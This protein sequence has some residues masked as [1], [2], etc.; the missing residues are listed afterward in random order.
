MDYTVNN[1]SNKFKIKQHS[2]LFHAIADTVRVCQETYADDLKEGTD[3][4]LRN[5]INSMRNRLDSF[6]KNI[7]SEYMLNL[8]AGKKISQEQED[9]D[10]R[11]WQ[12]GD[13][14]SF[15]ISKMAD[16]ATQR[17]LTSGLDEQ[18]LSV[19]AKLSDVSPTVL[20]SAVYTILARKSTGVR[21]LCLRILQLYLV[22]EGAEPESVSDS[23]FVARCLSAFTR[24]NTTN[25]NVLAIKA[26]LKEWL[27][28]CSERYARTE[29]AAT[30]ANF[31]KS[32]FCFFVL[33]IQ[34]STKG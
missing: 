13:N 21:D 1:L 3:E 27:E 7:T 12:E 25:P 24:S 32:L 4:L 18:V 2:V 15:R 20:R 9:P 17:I 26:I 19:S 22:D 5:F 6:L 29:R 8:R 31:L 23:R 34:K 11:K 28:E 33:C 30:R 10:A 14:I 16:T